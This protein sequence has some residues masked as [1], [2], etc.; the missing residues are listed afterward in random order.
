MAQ[1]E[2]MFPKGTALPDTCKVG[3]TFVLIVRD[4]N[5]VTWFVCL[6]DNVWTALIGNDIINYNPLVSIP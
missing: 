6:T 5:T 3:D 4:T 1:T 2:R